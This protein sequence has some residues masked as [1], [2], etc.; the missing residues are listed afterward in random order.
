[1][2]GALILGGLVAA[3]GNPCGGPASD[4]AISQAMDIGAYLGARSYSQT[5]ELE[6]DT[7]GAFIAARA[8][9]DP[10][11]GALIFLRPALANAGGPPHPRQPPRLRAA[12]GHRRRRRRRD[13]PPAG[14][15]P[16]PAPRPGRLT[17]IPHMLRA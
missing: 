9:Y 10:E 17:A 5:Y 14:P 11:R 8:G 12:P 15:R 3:A 6:A 2:L 13:P 1:M 16:H 7:L 4:Q